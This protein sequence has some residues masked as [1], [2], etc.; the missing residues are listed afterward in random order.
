MALKETPMIKKIGKYLKRDKFSVED[1]IKEVEVLGGHGLLLMDLWSYFGLKKNYW[2]NYCKKNPEIPDAMI[3]GKTRAG[4][5]VTSQ[6]M[7]KIKEGNVTCIIFYLKTQMGW[8]ETRVLDLT[9]ETKDVL[10]PKKLGD[11][12]IEASRIYQEIMK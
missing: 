5:M 1:F 4:V 3:R 2:Y 7:K 10:I 8:R 9:P 6:L 12:P 11:N